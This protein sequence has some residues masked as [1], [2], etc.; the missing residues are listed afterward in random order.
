MSLLFDRAKLFYEQYFAETEQPGLSKRLA[1]IDREIAATGTYWQH[2]T[3]LEYGARLA[4]RNSNRCIGR[5]FW[6][7]LKVR[8]MRALN[9]EEAVFSS[10]VEHVRKATNHGKI[11]PLITIFKPESAQDPD[12]FRIWNTQ[13][14]RYAGYKTDRE[15]LG[16]P[17]EQAFTQ[18]CLQLGWK[19]PGS[20]FDILPLVVQKGQQ[21]PKLFDLPK[22][23]V[24]E[25]PIAHPAFPAIETM[26]IKWYALPLISNM[27]LEVGGI[28]YPAAPFNGW[29]MGTE[30]ASRNLGD[31]N[32]Y[33]L[34][35]RVAECLDLDTRTHKT[36]WKDRALVELNAAVLYSFEKAAVTLVDHHTASEQFIH[37]SDLEQR[38][39]RPVQADWSWIVPPLSGSATPVF[40][41]DWPN[42]VKSPNFF[43]TQPAWNP[44]PQPRQSS[45]PFHRDTLLNPPQT[46]AS[47]THSA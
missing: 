34:L 33:N 16:D 25:V 28:V 17:A 41:K 35:P 47:Q 42:E 15:I 8:D 3:E 5:L 7:S 1:A 9:T 23:E 43:Y 44:E 31:A 14:I 12:H 39:G 36:L 6:K 26:G 13:V 32:R 38:A 45:C 2:P 30:I 46:R 11:R 37:F 27:A 40:H 24:L 22:H 4:W 29:Y 18:V 19:S 10:L 20:A 21:K